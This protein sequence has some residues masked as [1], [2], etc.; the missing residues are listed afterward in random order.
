MEAIKS[1][2]TIRKRHGEDR[3][4]KLNLMIDWHIKLTIGLRKRILERNSV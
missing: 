3:P 2:A 1:Y 4:L